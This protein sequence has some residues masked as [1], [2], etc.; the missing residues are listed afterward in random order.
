MKKIIVV[1]ALVIGSF[2][3][4]DVVA[5]IKISVN[6]TENCN[7]PKKECKRKKKKSCCKS[8][9]AAAKTKSCSKEGTSC[10]KKKATDA[11]APSK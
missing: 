6:T 9:A 11:A 8:E 7:H 4:S 1:L 3:A 10:C 5:A 2:V